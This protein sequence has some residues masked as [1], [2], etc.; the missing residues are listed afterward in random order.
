VNA[1]ASS[2]Y[3]DLEWKARTTPLGISFFHFR[4]SSRKN[5]R[6]PWC[7]VHFKLNKCV[8]YLHDW[9]FNAIHTVLLISTHY[10][11]PHATYASLI[12]LTAW[13]FLTEF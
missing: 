9:F 8:Y 1:S 11:Y 13:I 10:N 2:D 5:I 4:C 6:S 7:C 3:D 12:W